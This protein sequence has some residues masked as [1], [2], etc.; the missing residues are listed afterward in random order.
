WQ[1]APRERTNMAALAPLY[2]AANCKFAYQLNWSLTVY[3]RTAPG[4]ADWWPT[5]QAAT[6]ADGIRLL[7]HRFAKPDLSLFLVSTQPQVPAQLIPQR[8]KG[9]LQHLLRAALPKPF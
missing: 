3:W 9:R 2:T 1:C 4:A 6:E 7:Q 8:V 5:L